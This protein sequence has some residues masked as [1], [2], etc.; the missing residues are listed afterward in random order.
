MNERVVFSGGFNAQQKLMVPL[1][2]MPPRPLREKRSI[3]TG[4]RVPA[5]PALGHR[6]QFWVPLLGG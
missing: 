3:Q 6:V 5:R 1:D 2:Y 4:K